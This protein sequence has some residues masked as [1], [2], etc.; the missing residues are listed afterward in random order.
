MLF[1][2]LLSSL[3]PNAEE[4]IGD[5]HSGFRRNRTTTDHI[6]CSRKL[7]GKCEYNEAVHQLFLNFK[8]FYADPI[9]RAV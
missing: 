3:T 8:K 4:I 1:T 6:C 2:I 9:G 5:H 7:L